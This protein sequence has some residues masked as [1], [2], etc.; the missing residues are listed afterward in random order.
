M[1]KNSFMIA[2]PF[3]SFHFPE[4]G[5]PSSLTL[6]RFARYIIRIFAVLESV[7]SITN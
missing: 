3:L 5:E 4:C 6:I 7:I 2:L 1:A